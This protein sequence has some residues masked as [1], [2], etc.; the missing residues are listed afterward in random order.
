MR[1]LLLLL[2]SASV[3][4]ATVVLAGDC[5]NPIYKRFS[6]DHTACKDDNVKCNRT[7]V[8]QPGTWPCP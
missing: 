3:L 4:V 5:P 7:R 1:R 2:V 6:A 8:S